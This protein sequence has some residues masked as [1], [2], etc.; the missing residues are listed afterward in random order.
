MNSTAPI[1]T[2]NY[3]ARFNT[4]VVPSDDYWIADETLFDQDEYMFNIIL[5]EDTTINFYPVDDAGNRGAIFYFDDVRIPQPVED[6]NDLQ[7]MFEHPFIDYMIMEPPGHHTL[8]VFYVDDDVPSITTPGNEEL[9][10]AHV[11]WRL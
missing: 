5:H 8:I 10:L 3:L 11:E 4:A 9:H 1:S 6:V 2:F 7:V